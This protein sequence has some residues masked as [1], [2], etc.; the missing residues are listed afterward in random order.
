MLAA[1]LGKRA[2]ADIGYYTWDEPRAIAAIAY[3]LDLGIDVNARNEDGETALHAAAYHAANRVIQLLVER[4]ANLDARNFQDQTPLLVAQGHLVCCT[5]F[6][7]H[8]ETADLLRKSG[9]DV[10]A[11]S[12]LN[13]GL[14]SY[15]EDKFKPK[16]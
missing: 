10:N 5:T 4:R 14:V 8:T 12:R 11:G 2:N 1:G 7:R 6:V 15:V 13:F 3:G 16:E 9:A